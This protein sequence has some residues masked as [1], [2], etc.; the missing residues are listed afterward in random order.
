MVKFLL[1]SGADFQERC[2]GNFWC[3]EDQKSS[4]QD[5]LDQEIVLV[6]TESNYQ[7]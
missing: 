6:C 4:R 2:F 3:P 1:E 7:G 5:S